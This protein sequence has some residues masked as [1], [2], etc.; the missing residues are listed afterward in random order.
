MMS[1]DGAGKIPSTIKQYLY[2]RIGQMVL[3]PDDMGNIHEMII[4]N[5]GKII[6]GQPIGT[7]DDKIAKR[8]TLEL[9]SS[10]DHIFKF[11]GT[12]LHHKTPGRTSSLIFTSHALFNGQI[13]AFSHIPRHHPAGD[14]TGPFGLQLFFRTVTRIY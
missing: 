8:A 9:H 4:N 10:A 5:H 11:D 1:K 12:I 6:S 13:T 7:N 2:R 14:Q 3:A